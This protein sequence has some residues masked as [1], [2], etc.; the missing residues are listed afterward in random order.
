MDVA[1]EMNSGVSVATTKSPT[2]SAST[3]AASSAPRAAF[4]QKSA[5]VSPCTGEC[6]GCRRA[7]WRDAMPVFSSSFRESN[8]TPASRFS[9]SLSIGPPGA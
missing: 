5:V 2:A 1:G 9:V 7:I 8:S 4:S 6:S 3:S